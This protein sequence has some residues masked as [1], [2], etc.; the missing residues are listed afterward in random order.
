MGSLPS[1]EIRKKKICNM[2]LK[3]LVQLLWYHFSKFFMQFDFKI[4]N[5]SGYVSEHYPS[6]F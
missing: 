5:C 6:L 4:G 3:P 2:L 1:F